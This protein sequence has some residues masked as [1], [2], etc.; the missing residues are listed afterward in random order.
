MDRASGGPTEVKV[1]ILIRSMGPI[2]ESNMVSFLS[3]LHFNF[4]IHNLVFV[5]IPAQLC[6]VQTNFH[7]QLVFIHFSLITIS[8]G[9]NNISAILNINEQYD[10]S[11]VS[12][13]QTAEVAA[14]QLRNFPSHFILSDGDERNM[15]GP[16]TLELI[17]RVPHPSILTLVLYTCPQTFPSQQAQQIDRETVTETN[18]SELK[19]GNCSYLFF[20]YI[21]K[22]PT[23]ASSDFV[24]GQ[25]ILILAGPGN[26]SFLRRDW[27]GSIFLN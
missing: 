9:K 18:K 1:N 8:I 5:H 12:H 15:C 10:T 13:R 22:N 4:C 16:E 20:I 21:L 17:S 3:F 6:T 27:P 24:L 7:L 14:V 25:V 26:R 19:L 11:S 23:F 2:S